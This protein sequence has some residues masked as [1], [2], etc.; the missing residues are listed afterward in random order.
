MLVFACAS[1]A[2][3]SI[4]V[5]QS[6]AGIKLGATKNQVKAVLGKPQPEGSNEFFYPSPVDLRITFK[7]GRVEQILSYS[8]RQRANGVA[9][10]SYRADLQRAYPKARCVEG[11]PSYLYCVAGA[12]AQGRPSYTGFLFEHPDGPIVEVETGFGSLA[13]ALKH[14]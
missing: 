5:G 10:G 8:K 7:H 1:T 12:R 9:V 3:A 11:A 4:A 14:P 6:V 13:Q 2:D